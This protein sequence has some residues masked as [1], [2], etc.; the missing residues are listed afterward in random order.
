[1]RIN[2]RI[3]ELT[4]NGKQLRGKGFKDLNWVE[5]LWLKK[6]E[7]FSVRNAIN[8]SGRISRR[9]QESECGSSGPNTG[10]WTESD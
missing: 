6:L 10:L 9:S 2:L 4:P 5:W 3:R 1:M 8:P 7:L